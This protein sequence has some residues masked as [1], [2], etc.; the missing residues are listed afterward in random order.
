MH[1]HMSY[2]GIFV[3][4]RIFVH[5]NLLVNLLVDEQIWSVEVWCYLQVKITVD[6]DYYYVGTGTVANITVMKD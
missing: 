3:V 5:F 2:V 4:D 1:I 6:G